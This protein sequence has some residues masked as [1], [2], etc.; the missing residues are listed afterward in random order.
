ML[1]SVR[2]VVKIADDVTDESF[3]IGWNI[4]KPKK[5]AKEGVISIKPQHSVRIFA[6]SGTW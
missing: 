4:A 5:S 2:K 3:K 1:D 6:V